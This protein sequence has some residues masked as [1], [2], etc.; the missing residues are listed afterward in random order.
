[1]NL[2]PILK[3]HYASKHLTRN[4]GAQTAITIDFATNSM[5]RATYSSTLT[6][7]F[8]NYTY[9]KIVEVWVT[10][11]AGTGQTIN[12]A[13]RSCNFSFSYGDVDLSICV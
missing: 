8:S 9:G 11:T 12:L 2:Y 5:I 6:I 1:M 4:L 10:N 3:V 13:K 7:D